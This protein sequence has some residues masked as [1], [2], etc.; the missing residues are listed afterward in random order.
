[1]VH[2][3]HIHCLHRTLGQPSVP[4]DLFAS[5]LNCSTRCL[6]TYHWTYNA[7]NAAQAGVSNYS[8]FLNGDLT[9][10][11]TLVP[12]T[13]SSGTEI[14]NLICAQDCAAPVPNASVSA[15]NFCGVAGERSRNLV[16]NRSIGLPNK[17][18]EAIPFSGAAFQ[19]CK[20]LSII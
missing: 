9:N 16:P 20:L 1:M 2:C 8:V 13:G 6:N 12:L 19:N 10:N 3:N 18:C 15:V 14:P 4:Q 5:Q 17:F 11:C 7:A